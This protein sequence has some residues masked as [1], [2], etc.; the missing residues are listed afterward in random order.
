MNPHMIEFMIKEKQQ[1][2]IEE[3]EKLRLLGQVKRRLARERKIRRAKMML[4]FSDV[5]LRVGY[6]IKKK[7]KQTLIAAEPKHLNHSCR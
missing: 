4:A 2:M 7:Y 1:S 3:A 6:R 5:L